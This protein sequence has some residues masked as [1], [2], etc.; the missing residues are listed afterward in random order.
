MVHR[1]MHPTRIHLNNGIV[2][3]NT[4]GLPYNFKKLLRSEC[5]TGHINF[6]A[7]EIIKDSFSFSPKIDVWS[8]GCCL[9]YLETKLDPFEGN[10]IQETKRRIANLQLMTPITRTT[11]GSE[12]DR[13]GWHPIIHKLIYKCLQLDPITRPNTTELM[14]Y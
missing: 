12:N 11:K 13:N 4:V 10:N 8:L 9:F 14:A 1:D 6:S 2:K 5:F 3:F 7:P